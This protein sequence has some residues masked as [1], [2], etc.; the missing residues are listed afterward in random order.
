MT[1]ARFRSPSGRR[2]QPGQSASVSSG[3][4]ACGNRRRRRP[5]TARSGT[6]LGQRVARTRERT[7]A[8]FRAIVVWASFPR[9]PP[10]AGRP[11][12]RPRSSRRRVRRA[13]ERRGRCGGAR[14]R[15]PRGR[16][17]TPSGSHRRAPGYAGSG[18]SAALV[19]TAGSSVFGLGSC[20]APPPAG[21][22]PRPRELGDGRRYGRAG[23][24]RPPEAGPGR[25]PSPRHDRRPPL[26]WAG[27]RSAPCL[28]TRSSQVTYASNARPATDRSR[29]RPIRSPPSAWAAPSSGS[30]FPLARAR[31]CAAND[32]G[33]RLRRQS[34][35]FEP[36][37]SAEPGELGSQSWALRPLG[38]AASA[39]AT[40]RRAGSEPRRSRP[41]APTRSSPWASPSRTSVRAC[42]AAGLVRGRAAAQAARTVS[43]AAPVLRPP[44]TVPVRLADSA[45]P[46]ARVAAEGLRRRCAPGQ[47]STLSCDSTVVVSPCTRTE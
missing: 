11:R 13:R 23:A 42:R 24:A 44:R 43:S 21:P 4:G 9:A 37:A 28:S 8:S 22:R 19:S 45:W 7:A 34:A 5:E 31:V 30:R 32:G 47:A 15:A 25:R 33:D 3:F 14:R 18:R 16:A 41:C 17:G 38:S 36:A 2:R 10:R 20:R 1:S 35:P 6:R 46:R 29:L 40:G 39:S 26:S 27:G 12:A